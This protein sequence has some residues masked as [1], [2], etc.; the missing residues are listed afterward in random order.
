MSTKDGPGIR[1]VV[2]MQGCPLRCIY[3]HNPDT[4]YADRGERITPAEL[5]R[6]IERFVPYFGKDGGVT[7]S[8][9]EPLMQPDFLY[10]SI[11]L[12]KA[13]GINCTVD[14]AGIKPAGLKPAGAVKAAV[15][16]ADLIILDIKMTC[17]EDYTKYTGGSLGATLEFLNF[18]ESIKK[19]TWIRH[20]VIPGIND[21]DA[22]IDSLLALLEPYTCVKRVELL[23]FRTLCKEKYDALDIKFPLDGTPDM[24]E[25]DLIR[26]SSLIPEKYKNR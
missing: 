21:T 26:L 15:K 9:G 4:W 24:D 2:F 20:V 14:T 25:R 16:A 23:P 18:L 22:D 10:E 19:P 1:T 3:C 6:R 5:M 17:E 11:M 12:A 7:F 13:C 8:G